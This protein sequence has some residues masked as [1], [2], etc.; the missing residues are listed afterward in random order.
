M[1]FPAGLV[2][3]EDI[4]LLKNDSH[5]QIHISE[6][7][8][9]QMATFLYLLPLCSMLITAYVSMTLGLNELAII[10]VTGLALAGSMAILNRYFRN[11]DRFENIKIKLLTTDE[12]V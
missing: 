2:C 1:D 6:A 9:I 12:S 11:H 3:K 10:V 5:A 4:G 8:L 7:K